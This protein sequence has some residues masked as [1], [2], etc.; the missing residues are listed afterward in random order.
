MIHLSSNKTPLDE[1]AVQEF[2]N[3]YQTSQFQSVVIAHHLLPL[4]LIQSY[5]Y[6]KS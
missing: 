2:L 5:E 4:D 3:S 1:L 6:L